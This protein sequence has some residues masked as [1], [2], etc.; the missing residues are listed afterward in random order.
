MF[1]KIVALDFVGVC[2]EFE[3]WHLNKTEFSD[4]GAQYISQFF[5]VSNLSQPYILSIYRFYT[6]F[7][8]FI[9]KYLIFI[10][11]PCRTKNIHTYLY[12]FPRAA[13]VH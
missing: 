1:L 4:P 13:V 11:T 6:Q 7:I 5:L 2:V 10:E 8:K 3:H 12:F 9:P